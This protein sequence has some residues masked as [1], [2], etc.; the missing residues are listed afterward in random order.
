MD[1]D[2]GVVGEG[3]FQRRV[4]VRVQFDQHL[5]IDG[6]EQ[7]VDQGRRTR[8]TPK[9]TVRVEASHHVE[10]GGE[11]GVGRRGVEQRTDPAVELA[12]LQRL[13]RVEVVDPDSG[14]GVEDAEGRLLRAQPLDDHRQNRVLEDVAGVARVKDVAIVHGTRRVI[15]R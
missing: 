4:I 5:S 2:A 1:R 3:P 6:A 8:I 11:G 7:R 15:R 10:I 9:P 12:G 13:L 14:V